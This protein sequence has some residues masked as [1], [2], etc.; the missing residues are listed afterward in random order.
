[1]SPI[2]IVPV[3][4]NHYDDRYVDETVM[5]SMGIIENR[6]HTVDSDIPCKDGPGS[7]SSL[8]NLK[9]PPPRG[10]HRVVSAYCFVG[11]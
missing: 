6:Y 4:H 7:M 9:H 3:G 2:D 1:M 5:N 8:K 11:L 10:G